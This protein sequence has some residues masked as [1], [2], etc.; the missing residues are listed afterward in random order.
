M[1][2]P[3]KLKDYQSHSPLG[4]NL[5]YNK[6]YNQACSDWEAY[7]FSLKQSILDVFPNVSFKLRKL[8]ARE[9]FVWLT[10]QQECKEK[11][12]EVL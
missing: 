4:V 9:K 5:A 12:E 8:S 3:E 6:G 11:V 2:K 10:A 1:S 7:L